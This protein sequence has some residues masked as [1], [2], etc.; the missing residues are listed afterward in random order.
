MLG[1][2]K[3]ARG[4]LD[5]SHF[6]RV[7]LCATFVRSFLLSRHKEHLS[8]FRPR[9]KKSNELQVQRLPLLQPFRCAYQRVLLTCRMEIQLGCLVK[10]LLS[11]H[12]EQWH[13]PMLFVCHVCYR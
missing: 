2:V 12:E 3:Y 13:C 10:F 5:L 6:D 11:R 9:S 8:A 1:S 7:E 4:A